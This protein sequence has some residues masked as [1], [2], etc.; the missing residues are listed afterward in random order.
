[1]LVTVAGILVPSAVTANAAPTTLKIGL[2]NS[3]TGEFGSFYSPLVP[4]VEAWADWVNT[5]GGLNGHKVSLN[6]LNNASSP[7]QIVANA[8]EAVDAGDVA[9]MVT[10]QLFDSVAPYLH[11]V[12][13][14]VYGWGITPGFFGA[15]QTN[16]FS[17]TGNV[18]NGKSTGTIKFILSK[19]KT[20]FA[21]LSDASPADSGDLK[22]VSTLI[23]TLGGDVVYSNFNVDPTNTASELSVAQAVKGSGAQAVAIALLG[24][25]ATM[26]VD[27]SQVGA[28]NVW[29]ASGSD[30]QQTLPQQ[31]GPALNNYLFYFF[32]A[33]FTVNS[34][35]MREYLAAMKKYYP[36][37]EY[38]DESL[39][40]WV[41]AEVLAGGVE[42][43][44]SKPV[45]RASLVKATN[46]LK[47][48]TGGGILA[49]LSFPAAHTQAPSCFAFEQVQ[50]G[51]WVQVSGTKANPFYCSKPLS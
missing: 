38:N 51:K 50:N 46:T 24:S 39:I 42:K 17:Y 40:G 2:L 33:P 23:T 32:T 20:K 43:L 30:F 36:S 14:P 12:G 25:E 37:D 1:M 44:G 6:I 7:S 29:V 15:G 41:N 31:Y 10:D 28:G 5:H 8:H 45:T 16:F 21:V 35:G 47:N 26:Q 49:P 22:A 3:T 4:G 9:I 11:S 13:I 34:P 19:G 18:T 48:Y 27:L